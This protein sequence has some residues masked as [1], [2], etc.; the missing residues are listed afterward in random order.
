MKQFM[1]MVVLSLT[2]LAL[3]VP[4]KIEYVD[5]PKDITEQIMYHFVKSNYKE[6]LEIAKKYWVL[7][8]REI[9]NLGRQIDR[10]AD[11]IY[12]RFGKSLSHEFIKTQK[13][14]R[15][16]IRYY[17][18]QKFEN[19]AIYWEFTFYRPK[20]MWQINEI[21]FKDDFDMLFE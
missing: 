7:P 4:K 14:G 2:L 10:Q 13:V 16:F 20:A 17:F 9:D 8:D 15:S 21:E 1:V 5:N 18:L 19:H 12:K 3:D 11:L 6:G